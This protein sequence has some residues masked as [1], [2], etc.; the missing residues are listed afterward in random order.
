MK[1]RGIEP[2]F[3][4]AAPIAAQGAILVKIALAQRQVK[5]PLPTLGRE[6]ENALGK[7]RQ[8]IARALSTYNER[9]KAAVRKQGRGLGISQ[10]SVI[11]SAQFRL[12]QQVE[13]ALQFELRAARTIGQLQ[14]AQLKGHPQLRGRST[15]RDFEDFVEVRPP[16]FSPSLGKW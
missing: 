2:E 6:P 16:A 8:P 9:A 14:L 13:G 1:Q 12:A 4:L 7:K 5:A 3:E 11:A 10:Q 15:G